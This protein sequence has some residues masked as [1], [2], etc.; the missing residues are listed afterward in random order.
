M[1]YRMPMLAVSVSLF[2]CG[3]AAAQEGTDRCQCLCMA[4]QNDDG[5]GGRVSA[6]VYQSTE[7]T[8]CPIYND[9]SCEIRDQ[10][11]GQTFYGE[12]AV[13]EP[14]GAS[15]YQ[16]MKSLPRPEGMKHSSD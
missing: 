13:C 7:F 6:T 14:L 11:T 15:P 12:T 2:V 4:G 3:V 9:R 16:D 8:F 1:V 10:S 5:N